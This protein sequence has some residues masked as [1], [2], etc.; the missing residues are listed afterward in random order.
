[1]YLGLGA[2][3]VGGI[4]AAVASAIPGREPATRF[5]LGVSIGG[6][7]GAA[8][9]GT[10]LVLESPLLEARM[11][12]AH[13]WSCLLVALAVAALPAIGV[14][15]VARRAAP[16]RPLVLSLAAAAGTAALGSIAAQASCAAGDPVHLLL[17][18]VLAPAAGV[19]VLTLPLLAALR[20]LRVRSETAI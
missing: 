8:G 20:R 15:L 11:P 19:L 10:L 4:C 5:A 3:G 17:G 18:H 6:L 13:D 12:A 2:A 1:M 16:F 7:A 9:F 14:I